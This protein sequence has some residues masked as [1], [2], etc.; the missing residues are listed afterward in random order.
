MLL[1]VFDEDLSNAEEAE[2]LAEAM[3]IVHERF[4]AA[5]H[6]GV[7]QAAEMRG[8]ENAYLEFFDA[9][10]DALVAMIINAGDESPE[11]GAILCGEDKLRRF[12]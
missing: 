5:L 11:P 12:L 8:W 9:G 1:V 3:S 10:T 6:K 4:P 7:W 2:T